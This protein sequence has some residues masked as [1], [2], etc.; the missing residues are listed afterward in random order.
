MIRFDVRQLILSLMIGQLNIVS[1]TR[2]PPGRKSYISIIVYTISSN[3]RFF[4]SLLT[5]N[6]NIHKW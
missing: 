5:R 2:L 1:G 4:C 3:K 6:I